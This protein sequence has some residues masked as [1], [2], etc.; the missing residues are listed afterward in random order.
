MFCLSLFLSLCGATEYYV[1]PTEPTDTSCPA[2]PCLTLSQYI[3]D[4]DLYF[5]S[6][7]VFKF[8]PGLHHANQTLDMHNVENVS[9]EGDQ[10]SNHPMVM[11][12]VQCSRHYCA[13]LNFQNIDNLNI[14]SLNFSIHIQTLSFSLPNNADLPVSGFMFIAMSNLQLYHIS[15]HFT[16]SD[17]IP[18]SSG[19]TVFNSKYV[20]L[21][22]LS[23]V[24]DS[25][26]MAIVIGSSD[27][28]LVMNVFVAFSVYGVAVKDSR[29]V[30]ISF[31]KIVSTS[32][33]I[34][35]NSS[36]GLS[37]WNVLVNQ[38]TNTGIH[39]SS[40][41]YASILDTRVT[42]TEGS[43]IYLTKS[44]H[45][46]IVNTSIS[47]SGQC[48]LY[49]SFVSHT[50][51]SN[52]L[53]FEFLGNGIFVYTSTNIAIFNSTVAFIGMKNFGIDQVTSDHYDTYP[54]LYSGIFLEEVNTAVLCGI[55]VRNS[56]GDG[57]E[58]SSSFNIT[59]E[60]TDVA[61]IGG[62]QITTSN[63]SNS[64]I[65]LNNFSSS[66]TCTYTS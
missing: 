14:H 47:H 2:Q 35:F 27:D 33:G 48:G 10:S 51:V 29:N 64:R 13:G 42:H 56:K 63:T 66:D 3:S 62:R 54:V 18:R 30:D 38:S 7:T 55:L 25:D 40:C 9:L 12:T 46:D 45:A 15:V 59:I 58:I 22:S 49:L 41:Q 4:S 5:K 24:C 26:S 23:T 20:L 32:S 8:L 6:N 36:T 60:N 43:G 28:I 17:F 65:S 61:F 37:I 1:R 11:M 39:I 52:S 44:S 53:V 21:H 19:I 34:V 31:S 57:I 50:I 16:S